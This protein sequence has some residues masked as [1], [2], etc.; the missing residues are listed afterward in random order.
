VLRRPRVGAA[1]G[2]A[3]IADHIVARERHEASLR[4]RRR[5]VERLRAPAG[6]RR[7]HEL[8]VD[9]DVV[10][11][12]ALDVVCGGRQVRTGG[13]AHDLDALRDAHGAGVAVQDE[14]GLVL[15][16]RLAEAAPRREAKGVV[17][18]DRHASP[19]RLEAVLMGVGAQRLDQR[20]PHTAP[21][22]TGE[23][24]HHRE[25]AALHRRLAAHARADRLA[26]ERRHEQDGARIGP[27]HVLE[28]LHGRPHVGRDEGRDD[29]DGRELRRRRR[30][31]DLHRRAGYASRW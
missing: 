19:Q 16:A 21:A 12:V 5:A 18:A 3:R 22:P 31:R 8:L 9:R 26:A 10:D 4:Q 11:R 30:A 14:C 2:E 24:A 17:V 6:E 1:G 25:Q 29:G 15:A 13:E 7:R 23:H 20:A 28:L 27:E